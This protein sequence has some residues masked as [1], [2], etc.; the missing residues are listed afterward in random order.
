MIFK[1]LQK[2]LILLAFVQNHY[3]NLKDTQGV[4]RSRKS[5]MGRKYIGQKKRTDNDHNT[6]LRK[7]KIEQ[8]EPH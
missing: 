1:N 2:T 7:L 3:D 6:L 5:K 4:I 8:H